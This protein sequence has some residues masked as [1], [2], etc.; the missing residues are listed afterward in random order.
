MSPMR[1]LRECRAS[2][3]D[4]RLHPL[5][6]PTT[7]TRFGLRRMCRVSDACGLSGICIAAN[8]AEKS[9][10]FAAKRPSRPICRSRLNTTATLM[11]RCRSWLPSRPVDCAS[12]FLNSNTQIRI[13]MG[14]FGP[15]L[16]WEEPW[17]WAKVT[18]TLWPRNSAII[19][20]LWLKKFA[21]TVDG[22][23]ERVI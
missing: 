15:K 23:I 3:A 6:L 14:L 17:S 9:A 12:S 4:S 18:F 11:V 7:S 5:R 8:P 10:S 16:E 13:H 1:S 2:P 22:G 19:D 20:M 21:R